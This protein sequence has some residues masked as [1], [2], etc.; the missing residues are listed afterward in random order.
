MSA[1][2]SLYISLLRKSMKVPLM[3][4]NLFLHFTRSIIAE[5]IKRQHVPHLRS[6]DNGTLKNHKDPETTFGLI[7]KRAVIDY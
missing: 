7:G 2:V 6:A 1:I 5:S 4:S 3:G